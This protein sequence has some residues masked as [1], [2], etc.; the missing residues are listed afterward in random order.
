MDTKDA[1]DTWYH[2]AGIGGSGMSALAQFH[3]LAGGRTTGSDRAFDQNQR[4]AIKQQLARLGIDFFPQDGSGLAPE[5]TAL[6]VSTAVEDQ[7]PDIQTARHLGVPILHRSELLA[8]YVRRHKTVAVTG[9]SGKST[10]VALIFSILRDSGHDPSLLTGGPLVALQREGYLGN[11]WAGRSD[12]LVI[13][14]DESDGS[15]VRYEPWAGVLLNLRLDHKEPRELAGMFATFRAQTRGPF[16]AGEDDNLKPY[17]E[18]A[19]RFG[20]QEGCSIHATNVTPTATGSAF[21]LE[22]ISFELPIPGLHNVHNAVAAIATCR[23]LNVPLR[24]MVAP[25]K[26]FAGVSRR[27]QR[28]G[29]VGGV[30]VI[31]DFAH[32]PDKIA[33]AISTARA[34][35]QRILAI[36][37]PHGFGPTRFLKEA[38]IETF[39]RHLGPADRLW[40]PEIYYAGGTVTRDISAR[41]LVE[42]IE[43]NGIPAFYCEHRQ[44]IPAAV[45]GEARPGDVVLVMGA[46]DP[47]LT[48]FCQEILRKLQDRARNQTD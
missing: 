4:Q 31:D 2:F 14:A 22:G 25:L 11:A 38:L 32:N 6:V 48:D 41:D 12:L 30:E 18:D 9:T 7:V 34:R 20:L 3:A 46:R 36:F 27:F 47:S 17:G 23:A 10:T 5:C 45:T 28:V 37:Q 29:T 39:S 8:Q 19:I 15:L 26:A 44:N 13:E 40:L 21:A 33:A 43:T 16:L 42:A 24:E 35:S 1:R